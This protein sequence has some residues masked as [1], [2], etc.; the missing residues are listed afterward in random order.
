MHNGGAKVANFFGHFT[1]VIILAHTYFH[2]YQTVSH[3][4]SRNWFIMSDRV[5]K[6]ESR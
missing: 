3:E 5:I 6:Y 2:T 4:S 1:Q